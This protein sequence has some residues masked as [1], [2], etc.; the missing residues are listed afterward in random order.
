MSLIWML[1]SIVIVGCTG[2]PA[3]TIDCAVGV[4]HSDCAPDTFGYKVMVEQKEAEKTIAAIDDARC[5]ANGAN[6]GSQ[7]YADCRRRATGAPLK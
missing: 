1:A 4:G 2:H 5:I 7:A 3:D 6:P